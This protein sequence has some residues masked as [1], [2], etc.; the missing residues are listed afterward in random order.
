MEHDILPKRI[1]IKYAHFIEFI[2]K[3]NE[4]SSCIA[5][6][7]YISR[8]PN[9]KSKP[10]KDPEACETKYDPSVYQILVEC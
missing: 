9:Q 6:L 8:G 1:S 2:L 5:S 3:E 10:N 4:Y 7:N